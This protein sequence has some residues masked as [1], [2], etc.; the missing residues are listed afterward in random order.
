MSE[1]SGGMFLMFVL[2]LVQQKVC[3]ES[4]KYFSS[5]DGLHH[6]GSEA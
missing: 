4:E 3:L 2:R 1:R 5:Q 6:N